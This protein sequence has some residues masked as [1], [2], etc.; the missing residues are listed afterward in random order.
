MTKYLNN[1]FDYFEYKILAGLWA[2]LYSDEILILFLL[3]LFLEILDVF[4]RWLAQSCKCWRALYPQ[5]PGN[6][7][8]YFKFLYQAWRW[9]FVNSSSFRGGFGSGFC[10]KMLTYLLLLLVAAAVDGALMLAHVPKM[11]LSIIVTAL[12][13][14]EVCS[15]CENLGEADVPF[16]GIIKREIDKKLNK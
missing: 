10:G 11:F 6:L 1:V 16:I 15:I 2:A 9:R 12:V 8:I 3:F 7:W 14:T 13:T 5:S 4:T